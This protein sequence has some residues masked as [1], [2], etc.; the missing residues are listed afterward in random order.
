MAEATKRL[1]V[2]TEYI[3]ETGWKYVGS[4]LLC[5]NGVTVVLTARDEKRGVEALE[6]LKES[7]LS[8]VIYHQLDVTD[9]ASVDSLADFIK[10]QFGGLDI[11]T[12]NTGIMGMIITDPDALV[13]GKAVIKITIWLK[14]VSKVNYS[15]A[16]KVIGAFIPLLQLSDSPRIVNISSSTGNLK[17]LK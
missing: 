4:S 9:P 14:H 2:V 5:A 7:D 15:G 17:V 13:S 16:Q 11:L 6:N 1:A 12:N 8:H 10:T 3:E